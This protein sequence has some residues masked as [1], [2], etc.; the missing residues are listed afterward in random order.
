MYGR[1]CVAAPNQNPELR[2]I[3]TQGFGAFGE[4][5]SDQTPPAVAGPTE[6]ARAVCDWP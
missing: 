1:A 2:A 6:L 4:G 3:G 5:D